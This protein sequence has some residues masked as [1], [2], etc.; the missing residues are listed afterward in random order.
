RAIFD[1]ALDGIVTMDHEGRIAEFNPGAERIFGY[2]REEVLGRPLAE[3]L[4]PAAL[5]ERHCAGLARY[6]ATG[7]AAV[8][9]KRIELAGLRA[10]GSEVPVELSINRMPGDGPPFFAGFVRDLKERKVAEGANARLVSIIESSDDAIVCKSM[11]CI[12]TSW[13]HGAER[14]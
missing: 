2:S 14:L 10:D 12:I 1:T 6:L 3:V 13:N 9:G 8:L 4:I 5:R 11:E 7:E